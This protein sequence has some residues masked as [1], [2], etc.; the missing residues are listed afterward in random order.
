M[1]YST[2]DTR[3]EVGTAKDALKEMYGMHSTPDMG[4]EREKIDVSNF[5]DP[6]DRFIHGRM[7]MDT[8]AFDFYY[9]KP[10]AEEEN[11]ND[12]ESLVLA[13]YKYLRELEKSGTKCYF[14]L[15]YGD[16]TGFEWEGKPSVIRKGGNTNEALRFT[17]NVSCESEMTEFGFDDTTTTNSGTTTGEG[18]SGT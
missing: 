3:L 7:K 1:E 5:R 14:K 16:D 15:T 18:E 2:Q 6:H 4:S 9:N 12:D 8:L 17:L 11:E 13:S 10:T